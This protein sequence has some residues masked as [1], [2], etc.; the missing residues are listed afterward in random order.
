MESRFLPS[1]FCCRTHTHMHTHSHS[2]AQTPSPSLPLPKDCRMSSPELSPQAERHPHCPSPA[3]VPLAQR[4]WSPWRSAAL[5]LGEA[6]GAWAQRQRA[7]ECA[8]HPLKQLGR[9]HLC[10]QTDPRTGAR[11]LEGAQR[12]RSLPPGPSLQGASRISWLERGL[13]A[14]PGDDV[15]ILSCL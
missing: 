14:E 9:G 1:I 6:E 4:L 12:H 15:T 2:C 11:M 7:A 10:S 3:H 13:L 8:S 5:S